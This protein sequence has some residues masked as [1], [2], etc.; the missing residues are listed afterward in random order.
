MVSSF[1]WAMD[2]NLSAISSGLVKE[3]V[4]LHSL[5]FPLH[6]EIFS[7]LEY[8]TLHTLVVDALTFV[9]SIFSP[10]IA[11]T[12]VDLPLLVSPVVQGNILRIKNKY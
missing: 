4:C 3:I 6:V 2:F 8:L 1:V 5:S 11:L 9:G 7:S 10:I 12:M